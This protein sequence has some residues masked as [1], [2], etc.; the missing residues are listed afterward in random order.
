VVDDNVDAAVSVQKILAL[1]GHKVEMAFN[2]PD[3]IE[4][5]RTFRPQ[6]ILLDIGMPGMS[7]YEVARHL[8]AEPDLQGI[9][10]T[11]LTGYGQPEDRSR[12]LQAGFNYHLTKPPD[13]RALAELLASPEEFASK[14]QSN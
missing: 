13:P 6:L 5:A 11:A 4:R 9:I 7:G 3:A 1:W 10:I 2:G 8:R 12:S 14:Y